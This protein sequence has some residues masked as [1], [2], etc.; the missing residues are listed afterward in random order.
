MDWTR[1]L[2]SWGG[3]V[4]W[5]CGLESWIMDWTRGVDYGLAFALMH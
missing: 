3:L 5:T 1:G 2:D 4:D